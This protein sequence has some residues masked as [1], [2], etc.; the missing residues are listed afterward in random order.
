MSIKMDVSFFTHISNGPCSTFLSHSN[1]ER[2]SSL[3]ETYNSILCIIHW[4]GLCIT[5]TLHL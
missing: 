4:G 1:F 2:S 3:W 5:D